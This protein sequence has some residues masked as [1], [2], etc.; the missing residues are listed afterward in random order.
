MICECHDL[1]YQVA[2]L[3]CVIAETNQ[4]MTSSQEKGSRAESSLL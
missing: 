4:G 2:E 1:G 3:I